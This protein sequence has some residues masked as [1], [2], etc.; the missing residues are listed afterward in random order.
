[1][2]E[3]TLAVAVQYVRHASANALVRPY[4]NKSALRNAIDMTLL[5]Q[6]LPEP[7]HWRV[8]L[9]VEVSA[10]NAEGLLCFEAGCA[11][12]AIVV[13]KGMD[14][15]EAEQAL[16]YTV[17]ASLLGNARA[18]LSSVTANTGYGPVVLPPITAE[19]VARLPAPQA[20]LQESPAV[21]SSQ[22][23]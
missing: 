8:E 11:V 2:T 15:E 4:Q 17:G 7:D 18:L 9:E 20:L 16:R 1:M 3:K 22:P 19:R 21:E 13:T 12:E 10:T 5:T 23:E 14:A 6:P